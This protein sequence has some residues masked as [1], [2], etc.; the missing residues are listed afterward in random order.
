MAAIAISKPRG[1][2]IVHQ[3][4]AGRLKLTLRKPI[5]SAGRLV[6]C[7]LLAAWMCM[8]AVSWI[9]AATDLFRGG[10]SPGVT[11]WVIAWIVVWTAGGVVGIR[12]LWLFSSPL[13]AETLALGPEDLW[14]DP[15]SWRVS[16]W[17]PLKLGW[18]QS[19][20]P[21][22]IRFFQE[23]F[24]RRHPVRVSRPEVAGIHVVADGLGR[25]LYLDLGANG[26]AVGTGLGP[27]DV[28]WLHAVLTDW[29]GSKDKAFNPLNWAV[30]S[31]GAFTDVPPLQ[32]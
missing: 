19:R 15:G 21:F 26:I 17:V 8:W 1:S 32:G 24:R 31:L 16:D 22:G 7:I 14:Y 25:G 2:A 3:V 18:A 4:D 28:K 30:G 29:H 5:S 27:A 6:I 13:R 20:D 23:L 11:I 9:Y 10:G 12:F